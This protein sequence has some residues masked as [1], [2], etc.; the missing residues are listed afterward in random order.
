[1]LFSLFNCCSL[2]LVLFLGEPTT[3]ILT[4]IC[5]RYRN[6]PRLER[7]FRFCAL[8]FIFCP[9]SIPILKIFT[10]IESITTTIPSYIYSN[11]R[12]TLLRVP[13]PSAIPFL[14]S[15]GTSRTMESV[16]SNRHYSRMH[17]HGRYSPYFPLFLSVSFRCSPYSDM[18]S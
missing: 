1:M 14:V 4:T 13:L 16:E 9:F 18:S 12:T 3:Y 7:E 11:S 2:F 15:R 6:L 17:S 10:R 5:V 8:P